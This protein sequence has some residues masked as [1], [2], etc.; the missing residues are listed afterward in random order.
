MFNFQKIF[1][2]LPGIVYA[3]EGEPLTLEG[4]VN[5]LN[6]IRDFLYT[7]FTSLAIIFVILAA[8]SFLTARGDE[9]KIT[10]AKKEVFYAVV[11]IVIAILAWS[12]TDL[13]QFLL[14]ARGGSH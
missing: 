6:Y 2:S 1:F 9:K 7:A 11:A 14:S 10:Q 13:I 5:I 12:L 4:V 3:T 8:F